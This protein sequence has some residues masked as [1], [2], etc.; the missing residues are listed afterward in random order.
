MENPYLASVG[1]SEG[2]LE[3]RL[4]KLP[5][6]SFNRM[7]ELHDFGWAYPD[8]KTWAL[9]RLGQPLGGEA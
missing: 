8:L 5:D 9:A 4:R 3:Q 6:I 2:F 7:A 1:L